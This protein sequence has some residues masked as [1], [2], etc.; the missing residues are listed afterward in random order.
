MTLSII[1][2]VLRGKAYEPLRSTQPPIH[3]R[4]RSYLKGATP[5]GDAQPASSPLR[6]YAKG[7]NSLWLLNSDTYR[8]AH[9]ACAVA[10]RKWCGHFQKVALPH[11]TLTLTL[12]GNTQQRESGTVLRF[13]CSSTLYSCT[14]DARSIE[15][16]AFYLR[17]TAEQSPEQCRI[18]TSCVF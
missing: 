16:E 10:F 3:R 13:Y 9:N 17:P 11:L 1:R 14:K 12:V 8:S 7:K 4:R 2:S 5:R 6:S 15:G 18:S